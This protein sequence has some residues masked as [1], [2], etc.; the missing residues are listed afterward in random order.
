MSS[1][2]SDIK[3]RY[4][5]W[6]KMLHYINLNIKTSCYVLQK[7]TKVDSDEHVFKFVSAKLGHGEALKKYV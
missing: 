5:I 1:M 6:K 4:K 2:L 3:K 7:L